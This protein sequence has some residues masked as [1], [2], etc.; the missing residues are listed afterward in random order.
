MTY[1]KIMSVLARA[2]KVRY[3]EDG[4]QLVRLN[5]SQEEILQ[6]LGLIPRPEE[7]PRKK[8]G[9]PKKSEGK[10]ASEESEGDLANGKRRRGRPKGSRNRPK[11]IAG[12]TGDS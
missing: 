3:G 12:A 11:A 10:P 5:P 1:K 4:W 9:R 8:P 6:E 7:A 2:K